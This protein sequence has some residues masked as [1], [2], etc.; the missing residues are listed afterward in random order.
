VIVEPISAGASYTVASPQ[1]PRRTL[2]VLPGYMEDRVVTATGSYSAGLRCRRRRLHHA[3]G[4]L[5]AAPNQAPVVSAGSNQT[6]TLPTTTATLTGTATD[7]GLPNKSLTLAWTQVSGPGT[8]TFGTPTTASTQ[9]TVPQVAGTYVFKLTANDSS[10]STSAT[11]TLTVNPVV[12][13]LAVSLT[14][15]FVGPNVAGTTQKMTA[16]VTS[17]GTRWRERSSSLP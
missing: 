14:P 17:N 8:A 5:P 15:T 9:V 3:N 6:I 16:V 11:M 7:D 12:A 13:N 1:P 10:L 2:P 4:R